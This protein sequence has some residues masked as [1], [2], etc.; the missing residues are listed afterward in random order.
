MG[1]DGL[2]D[3]A[4]LELGQDTVPRQTVA[5]CLLR[6]GFKPITYKNALPM[7]KRELISQR[8]VNYVEDIIVTG[9]TV[10]LGMSRKEVIQARSY[11]V[12]E[13]SYIQAENHLD[14]LIQ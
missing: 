1:V 13:S 10:N 11:I 14:Y 6:I 9:D 12:H 5:N 4:C 3:V 8:Q 2:C 7:S